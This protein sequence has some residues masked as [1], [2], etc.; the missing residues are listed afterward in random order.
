MP[1][2]AGLVIGWGMLIKTT[3]RARN[4]ATANGAVACQPPP[5]ATELG[6]AGWLPT[7]LWRCKTR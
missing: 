3:Y 5:A 2:Q 7:T 1:K 4:C 6:D